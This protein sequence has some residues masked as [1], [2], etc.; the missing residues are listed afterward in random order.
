MKP[1]VV[2]LTIAACGGSAA[3][4]RQVAAMRAACAGD[5]VWDGHAC[6][7]RGPG[8]AKLEEGKQALA[9]TNLEVANAA[10][11]AAEKSGPPNPNTSQSFSM[12]NMS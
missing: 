9:A 10:F 2:L 11:D 5:Q 8:A 7:A 6:V 12:P 3:T 1:I 4:G